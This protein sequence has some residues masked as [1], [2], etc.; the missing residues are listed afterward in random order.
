[1]GSTLPAS[2][3]ALSDGSGWS[4]KSAAFG[5]G[6]H[7]RLA[8]TGRSGAAGGSS[9]GASLPPGSPPPV[10]PRRLRSPELGRR[11]SDLRVLFS[12][13]VKLSSPSGSPA[14]CQPPSW[15]RWWW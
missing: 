15:T 9:K 10:P 1:M 3:E 2:G 6:S 5:A 11:G 4:R 7:G 13:E 12:G 8:A 14:I